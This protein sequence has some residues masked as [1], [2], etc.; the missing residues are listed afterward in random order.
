MF[1]LSGFYCVSCMDTVIKAVTSTLGLKLPRSSQTEWKVGRVLAVF[2]LF[3]TSHSQSLPWTGC[4]H[5]VV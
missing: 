3:H 1:Q 5:F 2:R 4:V